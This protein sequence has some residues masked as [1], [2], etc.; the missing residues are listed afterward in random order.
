MDGLLIVLV[1]LWPKNY[2]RLDANDD[3]KYIQ[4]CVCQVRGSQAI[5]RGPFGPRR[6]KATV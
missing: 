1:F 4:V 6:N 2:F 5:A 3:K